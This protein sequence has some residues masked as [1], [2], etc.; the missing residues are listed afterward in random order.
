MN[1]Y[2]NA[3]AEAFVILNL[4]NEEEYNKIPSEM[5][6]VISSNMN[7]EY[8]YEI[9]DDFN[10]D[11]NMLVETKAILFNIFRDYLCTEEQKKK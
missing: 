5:L 2:N 1:N 7:K 6:N 8:Y 3:F 9:Q 4:L 10:L 11:S